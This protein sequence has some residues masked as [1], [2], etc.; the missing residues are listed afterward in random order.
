MKKFKYLL[1]F[2]K[3]E[4]IDIKGTYLEQPE[5]KEQE[6]YNA[7]KNPNTPQLKDIFGNMFPENP[8]ITD[9]FGLTFEY[10]KGGYSAI[11]PENFVTVYFKEKFKDENG[12][13]SVEKA[14]EFLKKVK[15]GII[16]DTKKHKNEVDVDSLR[17]DNEIISDQVK[18]VIV[19]GQP[20]ILSREEA[21]NKAKE[22]KLNLVEISPKAN[23]PICRILDYEKY[24]KETKEAKL[25]E[26]ENL[27]WDEFE[28]Y[29]N[30]LLKII[31]ISIDGVYKR[32]HISHNFPKELIGT[33][34]GYLVFEEFIKYTGWISHDRLES[35]TVHGKRII[36]RIVNDPDFYSVYFK[37][38]KYDNYKGEYF[39]II[40]RL[41]KTLKPIEII[42]NFLKKF[43]GISDLRF[44]KELMEEHKTGIEEISSLYPD[45]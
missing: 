28:K 16:L 11:F 35:S 23:P 14:E 37:H 26:K 41:D 18:L 27:I 34:I 31:R 19:G 32:I 33:G 5:K 45:K 42:K 21:I 29:F 43:K 44:S 2:K 13:Y 25:K 17:I 7:I 15:P 38:D 20:Q 1:T 10:T 9:S 4:A 12:N 6:K 3:F 8:K 30:D 22:L 24:K 40:Y 36:S 39:L